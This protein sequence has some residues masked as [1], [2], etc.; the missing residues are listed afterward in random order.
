MTRH[1]LVVGADFDGQTY[2]R[3]RDHK[4]LTRQI[5]KVFAAMIDGEWHTLPELNTVTGAPVQS[6]SARLRDLRKHKFGEFVIEKRTRG[7]PKDGL[8]EYHLSPEPAPRRREA[9]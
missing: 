6:I 9:A 8:W 2:E 7:E 5:E 4:R 1:A 3:S